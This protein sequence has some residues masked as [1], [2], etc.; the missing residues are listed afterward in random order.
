MSLPILVTDR[1]IIRPLS[2]RDA[3]DMYEYAKTDFVGPWAG[4]EPHRSISDTMAI[5]RAMTSL[6]GYH[7]LGNWAIIYKE[8]HKMIGTIEFFN[9]TPMFKAELGYALNNNYWGQGIVPEAGVA[10]LEY[11]FCVLKLKRVEVE[12]FTNN[13]RSQKVCEKLGFVY[14]GTSRNGYLRY[15]GKVFDK[16][17]YGMTDTDYFKKKKIEN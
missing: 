1:L 14:E 3:E 15:D 11:G 12:V 8:N 10:V 17:S 9:Y 13:I 6:T 2:I 5:I 4:W 7:Q 16:M